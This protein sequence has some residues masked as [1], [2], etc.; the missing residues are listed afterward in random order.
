MARHRGRGMEFLEV[1]PEDGER[2]LMLAVLLDAIRAYTAH[3]PP[4]LH[5]SAY[6]AWLRERAW[7]EAE[8][9]SSAF[10]FVNICEVLGLNEE[11]VRRCV[12]LP[13]DTRPLPVRRYAAKAEEIWQRQRR[14]QGRLTLVRQAATA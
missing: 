7:F 6:R 2:R 1:L 11:Y 9:R 12:L 13:S 14:D 3:K 10:S 5:L 8:D 4:T